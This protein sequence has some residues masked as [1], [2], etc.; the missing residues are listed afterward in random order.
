MVTIVLP[1]QNPWVNVIWVCGPSSAL[2]EVSEAG[3][4]IINVP[5]GIHA[6]SSGGRLV[7]GRLQ[8]RPVRAR[9]VDFPESREAQPPQKSD[10]PTPAET[11]AVRNLKMVKPHH[12]GRH[13]EKSPK[14]TC[15]PP[16]AGANQIL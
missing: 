10:N 8:S 3:L 12:A 9:V 14:K 7:K 11:R 2:R 16:E 4:P 5:G 1:S 13:I 15:R 6:I